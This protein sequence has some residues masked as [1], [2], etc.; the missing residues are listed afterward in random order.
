MKSETRVMTIKTSNRAF[1][2]RPSLSS[3]AFTHIISLAPKLVEILSA[4][5]TWQNPPPYAYRWLP[6]RFLPMKLCYSWGLSGLQVKRCREFWLRA[7]EQHNRFLMYNKDEPE[8][9]TM[10]RDY[11]ELPFRW[12]SP[13][14]IAPSCI[15]IWKLNF[16]VTNERD[17]IP[18]WHDPG[19]VVASYS[20]QPQTTSSLSAA[21]Q[22]TSAWTLA[23]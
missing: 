4:E 22:E 8:V 21:V 7:R 15:S 19:L 6:S 10:F 3:E 12:L 13:L 1:F 9:K 2:H 11:F 5:Q 20:L 23:E 17:L 14:S 16:E 18:L